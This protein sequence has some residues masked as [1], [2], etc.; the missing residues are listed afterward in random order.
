MGLVGIAACHLAPAHPCLTGAQAAMRMVEAGAGPPRL[1]TC[2]PP[3][4][5]RCR[6]AP[7]GANSPAPQLHDTH[8][9]HRLI[10]C[11][12]DGRGGGHTRQVAPHA[13]VQRLAAARLQ[14]RADAAAGAHGL[15]ARLR[16]TGWGGRRGQ[17]QAGG[18]VMAA[19]AA[20]EGVQVGNTGVLLLVWRAP[21]RS[22]SVPRRFIEFTSHLDCVDGI[23]HCRSGVGGQKAALSAWV[24]AALG[25]SPAGVRRKSRGRGGTHNRL[26]TPSPEGS[27]DHSALQHGKQMA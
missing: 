11:N 17:Q 25:V 8:P 1:L 21:T 14:Q 20:E 9:L 15:Q 13:R 4:P 16:P 10:D 7:T 18:W 12:E 26:A 24:I 27:P 23:Q 22:I 5:A 3:P 2:L 19:V 6:A